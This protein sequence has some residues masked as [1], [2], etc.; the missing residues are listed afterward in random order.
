MVDTETRVNSP[1][2]F[3]GRL[4]PQCEA[5]QLEREKFKM[6]KGAVSLTGLAEGLTNNREPK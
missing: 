5:C 3:A 4:Q 1:V 6:V 2:C